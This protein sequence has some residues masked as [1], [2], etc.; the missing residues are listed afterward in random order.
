MSKAFT[1]GVIGLLTLA[2]VGGS[3]YILFRPGDHAAAASTPGYAR[4]ESAQGGQ[5]LGSQGNGG[6][7]ERASADQDSDRAGAGKESSS[8]GGGNGSGPG[9]QAASEST[10]A[11]LSDRPSGTWTTLN[12][13]VTAWDGHALTVRTDAGPIDV[14]LGPAWYWDA[15]G[16][17]LEEG[18]DLNVTGFYEGD[19]F[20]V[21]E[22]E[23]RTTQEN[24]FLRDAS[25]RPQWAAR[26][27]GRSVALEGQRNTLWPAS[28][29]PMTDQ[30]R[31]SKGYPL[32]G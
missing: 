11:P 29:R 8:V 31:S 24:V 7:H 13:E 1:M 28:E 6:I 3:V 30:V 22:I 16:I 17:V 20:E 18:D 27:R 2:L 25:G 5:E 26:G 21:A 9:R 4:I 15:N 10:A 12:G 19:A 23:N 32:S 14:H